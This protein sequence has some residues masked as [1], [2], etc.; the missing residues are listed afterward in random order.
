M[1]ECEFLKILCSILLRLLFSMYV[2]DWAKSFVTSPIFRVHNIQSCIRYIY[3]LFVFVFHVSTCICVMPPPSPPQQTTTT[4]TKVLSPYGDNSKDAS[5]GS[6][7]RTKLSPLGIL[8]K[9]SVTIRV[10]T[11]VV[12]P[13]T[14]PPKEIRF[15]DKLRFTAVDVHICLFIF[16][17][18][19]YL[20]YIF[21][22]CDVVV[23][24]GCYNRLN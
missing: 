13:K 15:Q 10:I 17:F 16:I 2:L 5:G 6:T 24:H 18:Y 22:V 7:G 14:T 19:D 20:V 9:C 12:G 1:I 3:I 21:R 11:V 4:T 23:L 8:W